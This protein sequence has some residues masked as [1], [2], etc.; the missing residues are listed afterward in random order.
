M[1]IRFVH[2]ERE[3]LRLPASTNT[4]ALASAGGTSELLPRRGEQIVAF[5]ALMQQWMIYG[6]VQVQR[7]YGLD[8]Q[9]QMTV[10]SVEMQMRPIEP[11]SQAPNLLHL[12][13]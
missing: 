3:I 12:G 10:L 7:V 5:D 6:I 11:A 1:E 8:A 2:A 4:I 9:G 13:E